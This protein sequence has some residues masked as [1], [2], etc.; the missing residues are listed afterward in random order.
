MDQLN[1]SCEESWWLLRLCLDHK[2]INKAIKHNQWYK[3]TTDDVLPELEN[4]KY[5]SLLDAKSGYW[6]V[7]LDKESSL[8]TTFNT[9]WGRYRTWLR[10]PFG[11]TVAGDVFQERLDRVLRSVPST[12]SIADNFLCPGIF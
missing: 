8:L 11:L 12:T 3:R 2:G 9:P 5:L 4:S 1:C 6:H 7:L 10:L